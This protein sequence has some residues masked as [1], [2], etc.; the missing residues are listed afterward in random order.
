MK[1]YNNFF[2]VLFFCFSASI[3][4]SDFINNEDL[5]YL[6]KKTRTTFLAKCKKGDKFLENAKCLNFLGLKIYINQH[7]NV[8]IE[9]L[10]KADSLKIEKR[11]IDI[12]GHAKNK[13]SV[14]AIK[15]LAWIYSNEQSNF[16]N[17]E[18][19]A[20]LFDLYHLS[21]NKKIF[22]NNEIYNTSDSGSLNKPNY[23]NLELALALLGKIKVYH[24]FSKPKRNYISKIE[25][26]YA[27]V[28]ITDLINKSKISD[29][30]LNK[31]KKKVS[32]NNA[33]IINFLKTDLKSKDKALIQDAKLDF[34][35]LKSISKLFD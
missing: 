5:D 7:Q 27:N 32:A 10:S 16:Q 24:D 19:S 26:A 6:N 1:S 15:N 3:Y 2:I 34:E 12:L 25:Y 22:K 31:I 23:S 33:I 13:G 21:K 35:K 20:S 4:C 8:P 9:F 30:N 29:L 17:L 11:A 28:L 18:K 14:D